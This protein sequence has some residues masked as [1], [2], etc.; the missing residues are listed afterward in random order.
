MQYTLEVYLDTIIAVK[1][2]DLWGFADNSGNKVVDCQY[3]KVTEFNEFGYAG[4][5][6]D[7]KW[8]VI[9]DEGEVVQ[10]PI[11]EIGQENTD[12][13][14]IGKYYGVEYGFGEIYYTNESGLISE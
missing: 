8:G 13:D 9:N 7:G 3:E 1:E 14:F 2:N 11:Y 6:Q 4:I 5:K 12:L 10:E